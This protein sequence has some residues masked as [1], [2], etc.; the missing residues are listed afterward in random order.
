M[1]TTNKNFIIDTL[2]I[3][4]L[5]ITTLSGL[6][7]WLGIPKKVNFYRSLRNIHNWSGISLLSLAFYHFALHWLWYIKTGLNLIK[8]NN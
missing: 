2:L 8:E 5:K 4:L 7:L 6:L 3:I 1:N